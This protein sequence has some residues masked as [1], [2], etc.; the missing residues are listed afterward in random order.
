MLSLLIYTDSV[1]VDVGIEQK[2][3]GGNSEEVAREPERLGAGRNDVEAY[4]DSENINNSISGPTFS[5][6]DVVA[7]GNDLEINSQEGSVRSEARILEDGA[8][9]DRFG[10]INDDVVRG[11]ESIEKGDD[12]ADPNPQEAA[13]APSVAANNEPAPVYDYRKCL[14]AKKEALMMKSC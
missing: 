7:Q 3:I 11:E 2:G 1:P 8:G 6:A 10:V 13:K 14:V 4:G 5:T 12:I 9:L